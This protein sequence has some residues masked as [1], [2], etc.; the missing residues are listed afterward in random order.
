M[1]K[2]ILTVLVTLLVIMLGVFLYVKSGSYNISQLD[3]HIGLTKWLIHETKE[4]SID[5]RMGENTLPANLK[6]TSTIIF[7]FQRYHG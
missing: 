1:R 5:K 3:P 4:N 6:D 7:G 2:I